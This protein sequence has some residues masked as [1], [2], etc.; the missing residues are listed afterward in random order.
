M[1]SDTREL[2]EKLT[3]SARILEMEGHGDMTLGHVS[4]RDPNGQGFWMK[5][6]AAG[7]GEI[8]G[9]EDF[10]LVDYENGSV[11]EGKGGRHSEWPIHS[12]IYRA[13][14][15]ITAVAHTHPAAVCA[16]SALRTDLLPLG[17]DANYFNHPVPR[18][19]ETAVLIK[20]PKLGRAMAQAMGENVAVIL[21]NHGATFCGRSV[22]EM[23]LFGIWLDSACAMH[24]RLSPLLGETHVPSPAELE[25]RQAQILSD[26]HVG[27]SWHYLTRKLAE[28]HAADTPFY[29]DA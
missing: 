18:F 24:L 29:G 5:R 25:E 28:R 15:D 6:N 7:L 22:E 14:P 1:N 12:E 2:L 3:Q 13:R 8:C 23:T 20:T 27:H 11:L 26:V 9:P 16:F 4:A 17:V 19:E 10:V 21:A